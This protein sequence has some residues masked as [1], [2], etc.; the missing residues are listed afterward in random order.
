MAELPARETW[1]KAGAGASADVWAIDE[2]RVLKLFRSDVNDVPV[3]LEYAAGA[4]AADQALPVPRPLARVALEGR[5]GIIFE[6]MQGA[7][8]LSIITRA[9]WRMWALIRQLADL[10]G[11]VHR[12]PG[13]T[14]LPRQIDVLRHRIMRSRAGAVAVE[15]ALR[16]IDRVE[17]D[18]AWLVHGDFHP[19]NLL[20]SGAGVAIIDWAQA[21]VGLP[22]ADVARTELLLRFGG[23][24]S[25]ATAFA[26]AVTARWY[27]HCYMRHST[28]SRAAIDAWRLPVAVAWHRGQ[29]GVAEA[30]LERW[31]ACLVAQDRG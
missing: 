22:A 29:L 4:W 19:G 17:S 5:A 6:R 8:M 26:G 20:L 9:P 15:A 16:R 28:V 21:A 14:A 25:G 13:S 24:G 23:G 31:I 7:D 12:Q 30:R 1:I 3:A 2:L 27:R 10:H 11:K 18:G